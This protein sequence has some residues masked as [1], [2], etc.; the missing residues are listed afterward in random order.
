M[1]RELVRVKS[2]HLPRHFC[3]AS[4]V[5][6]NKGF[7]DLADLG[8]YAIKLPLPNRALHKCEVFQY[9]YMLHIDQDIQGRFFVL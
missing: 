1:A 3:L 5:L 7:T 2:L 8:T 6:P 9:G 4:S